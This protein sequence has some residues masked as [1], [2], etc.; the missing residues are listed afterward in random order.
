MTTINLS[1]YGITLTPAKES[2][3][4]KLQNITNNDFSKTNH[5]ANFARICEIVDSGLATAKRELSKDEKDKILDL[6][7]SGQ[8]DEAE[9]LEKMY[10]EQWIVNFL[11][12]TKE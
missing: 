11:P 8:F 5:H 3:L 2:D 6:S 9:R 7:I 12:Y 10:E 4:E 1:L